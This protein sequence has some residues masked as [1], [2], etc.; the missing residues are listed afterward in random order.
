MYMLKTRSN[1]EVDILE[2]EENED[3]NVDDSENL[4]TSATQVFFIF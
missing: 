4:F 3:E 1:V 2:D